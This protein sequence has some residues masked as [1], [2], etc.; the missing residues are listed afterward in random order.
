MRHLAY[1]LNACRLG[2]DSFWKSSASRNFRSNVAPRKRLLD[3]GRCRIKKFAVRGKA[4][5]VAGYV[6]HLHLW[7]GLNHLLRQHAP[8]HSGH[9]HVGQKE[10]NGTRMPSGDFKGLRTIAGLYYRISPLL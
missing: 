5:G 2:S 3:K 7:L 1:E 9:H 8:I 4:A 10:M 6:N